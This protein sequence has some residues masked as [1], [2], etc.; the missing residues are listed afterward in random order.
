ML[1]T[2]GVNTSRLLTVNS[3]FFVTK[4]LINYPLYF[5][6]S[7]HQRC[8]NIYIKQCFISIFLFQEKSDFNS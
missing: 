7:E 2:I 6:Q 8:E 1:K 3:A 5:Q 4:L